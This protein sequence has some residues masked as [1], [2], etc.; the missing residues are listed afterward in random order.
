MA[1]GAL[2]DTRQRDYAFDNLKAVLIL[3][4]VFG[5]LLV[6]GKQ[7]DICNI[8]YRCIYIFHMPLFVFISGYF[9]KKAAKSFSYSVKTA[10]IPYI[11]FA[12]IFKI[13]QCC[14]SPELLSTLPGFLKE[15]PFVHWYLLCLFYWRFLTPLLSKIKF[16]ILPFLFAFGI[17]AGLFLETNTL[18]VAR[19]ITFFPYYWLGFSLSSERV[20][21]LRSRSKLLQLGILAVIFAASIYCFINIKLS[22]ADIFQLK[23]SYAGCKLEPLTG[24]LVRTLSYAAA[25][26]ICLCLVGV[27]PN[28]KCFLSAVGN[29]TLSVYIWHSYIIYFAV[30]KF[31]I[32]DNIIARLNAGGTVAFLFGCAVIITAVLCLPPF[33]TAANGINKLAASLFALLEK[34]FK[35]D[36]GTSGKAA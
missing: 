7:Y 27:T 13:V 25:T 34:P 22:Y 21:A 26:V 8:I 35:K 10:L 19:A 18:S 30:R 9:S 11:F 23:E 1:N 33:T 12:L 28:R 2:K 32:L 14:I 17:A 36:G 29:N 16:P 6:Q 5:H 15:V 4:V 24:V 20:A 3:L 31:H